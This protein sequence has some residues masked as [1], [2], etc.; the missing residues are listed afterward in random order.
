VKLRRENLLMV[1]MLFVIVA[2]IPFVIK[3]TLEMGRVHLFSRQF[4]EE[5]PQRF[6]GPGN[7]RFIL[8]LLVAILMGLRSGLADAKAGNPP[9]LLAFSLLPGAGKNCSKVV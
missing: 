5:L 9:F 6:T 3:D 2:T 4:F 1:L 7:F 8:Q